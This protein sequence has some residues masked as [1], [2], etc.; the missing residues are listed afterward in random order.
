MKCIN[1][2]AL[3]AAAS[4]VAV[5]CSALALAGCVGA[6]KLPTKTNGPTGIKLENN[7]IDFTF[8]QAGSTRREEV[9]SRLSRIDT[10]YSNPGM[11]W[12]RWSESKSG[13]FVL[14]LGG[15]A[16]R[17]WHA[18][19]LL[20]SFDE[21]GMM[22]SKDLIDDEKALERELRLQ[23]A[24]SPPLDLSQSVLVDD[25]ERL[26][27]VIGMTLTENGMLVQGHQLTHGG[28]IQVPDPAKPRTVKISPLDVARISYK[29]SY[30]GRSSDSICHGF[31][32]TEKTLIGKD[33][34]FCTSAANLATIFR[35]LQQAGAPS[36]R[37][38]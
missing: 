13:Y 21:N 16:A 35:Y 15:G 4:I 3:L 25:V 23:L 29:P 8:L 5:M 1:R 37:W 19:N 33:F 2:G 28:L 27:G 12:G 24:K 11:F 17:N 26:Y 9:V 31:H 18:R 6:T 30:G 38:E 36:M 20:V 7:E 14:G 10:G 22:Q 32:L 34:V